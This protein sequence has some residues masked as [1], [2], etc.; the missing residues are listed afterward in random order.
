MGGGKLMAG[1]KA[2]VTEAREAAELRM[3]RVQCA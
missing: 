1:A 3:G 2:G